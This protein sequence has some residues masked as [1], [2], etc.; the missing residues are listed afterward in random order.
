MKYGILYGVSVG[1]GDPE[2]MTVKAVRILERCPVVAAPRTAGEKT[3]ALDIASGAADLTGKTILNLEFAMTRDPAELAASHRAAADTLENELREGRDVAM[4]NLGDVSVD[5]TFAYMMELLRADGFESV[6]IP[7]VPSFC[8]VAA[9]LGT[10]LTEM[11]EPLHILPA[12]GMAVDE[13]LRL[14]GTK[15]LMKT[16]RAM[17]AVRAAIRRAGL[18]DRTQLVQNCGLPDEKICRRL[19]EASDE[20]SYFTTMIVKP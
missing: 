6:M 19:E 5:S 10:G 11:N 18:A 12:G 8:A 17:P 2:L 7:G 13:A 16:G 20:I 15:V 1:P 3:L 9:A 14:P 4:L